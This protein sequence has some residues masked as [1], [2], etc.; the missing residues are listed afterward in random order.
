MKRFFILLAIVSLSTTAFGGLT[1]KVQSS[2][3]GLR[4]VTIAG[5]VAVDGSRMRMDVTSG[6]NLLFKDNS[7]VLSN[8][9]GKTMT[10]LDPTNRSYY[11]LQLDQVVGSTGSM[12]KNLGGMVKLS[13][14]N[15]KVSVR[16]EGNG[17]AIEGYRTQKSVL[18]TSY[19]MNIDA[20]GQKM[21]SHLTMTTESWMTDELSSE[22]SSFLQTRGF[23]TGVENLDK[24]IDAQREALKGFPL[25]QVSTVHL[26]REGNDVTMTTTATVT[27]IEKK[28]LD[29]A[30]FAVPAG[31]TKVDDPITKMLKQIRP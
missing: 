5:T 29:A 25:K 9:G 17:G 20:M 14:D 21:T 30:Q 26:Q 16:N 27:N 24:L 4:N 18:D 11:E 10:V 23:R 31:Y 13:F 7:V 28:T 19:D 12:L 8:D 2:T 15:P 3:N 6:D 22:F 1:Y